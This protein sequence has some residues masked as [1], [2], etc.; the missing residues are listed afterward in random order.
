MAEVAEDSSLDLNLLS[1][2][3]GSKALPK[4]IVYYRL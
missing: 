3:T 4:L 1:Y 2:P